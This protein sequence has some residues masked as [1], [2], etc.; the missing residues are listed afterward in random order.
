MNLLGRAVA[1]PYEYFLQQ[2]TLTDPDNKDWYLRSTFGGIAPVSGD[3]GGGD[4]SGRGA[5]K[6]IPASSKTL[7]PEAGGY[8][9]NLAAAQTLFNLRLND[10][11]GRAENSSM[12]LRQVGSR[13]GFSD[14]S[15]Q[16]HSTANAYVVQGGGEVLNAGNRE[17]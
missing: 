14:G 11:E 13:T 5:T 3:T 4:D 17:E 12:W 1:G 6:D 2:G 15:G 16:L 10:R 8:M 9:A 7:R